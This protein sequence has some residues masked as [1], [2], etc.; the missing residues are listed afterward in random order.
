VMSRSAF[1]DTKD[2]VTIV[3]QAPMGLHGHNRWRVV[4]EEVEETTAQQESGAELVLIEEAHLR[5]PIFL[6]PFTVMTE[7]SAHGEQRKRYLE[8]VKERMKVQ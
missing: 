7:Q 2:G 4:V 5:G 6:M 3:F 1:V 8:T